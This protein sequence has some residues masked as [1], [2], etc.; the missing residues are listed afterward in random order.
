[1][2][3][4]NIMQWN[5]SNP[6]LLSLDVK[7][8]HTDRL[9]HTNNVTYL[10]WMETISWQHVE[11][12]GMGW[13]VQEQEGKA[14]AIMRTEV[15]YLL[16]SHV[17]DKLLLGTWITESDGRLCSAREF[18]LVRPDDGKTIMRALSRYACIQLTTGKPCR[19]PTC[20]VDAHQRAI[21]SHAQA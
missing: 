4:D 15:D 17:N 7:A 20:F 8:E 10:H 12:I 14:M 19:M 2:M 1:M 6:F 18:Q 5:H 9:G 11:S 21:L 13:N 16:S 3:D